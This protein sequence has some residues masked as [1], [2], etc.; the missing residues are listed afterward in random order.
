VTNHNKAK[1]IETLNIPMLYIHARKS[2]KGHPKKPSIISLN[3][4]SAHI[5]FGE[6][7]HNSKFGESIINVIAINPHMQYDSTNKTTLIRVFLILI[8]ERR[9]IF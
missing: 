1:G 3:I 5:S 8:K 4:R 9:P 7:K 6:A 2:N